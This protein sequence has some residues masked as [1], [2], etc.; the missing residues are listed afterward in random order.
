MRILWILLLFSISTTS[1]AQGEPPNPPS[2]GEVWK[3][4]GY[5]VGEKAG[6]EPS[7]SGSVLMPNILQLDGGGYRMYYNKSIPGQNQIKYAESTDGLNWTVKGVALQGSSNPQD[8]TYILGGPSVVKV[9][10]GYRM[11]YRCSPEQ[12]RGTAPKLHIRSAFSTDGINFKEE[13]IRIEIKSADPSSSL[14]LAGHGS[15]YRV[16]DGTFAAIFSANADARQ[17]SDLYSATSKDGLVWGNFKK[18]Y[19]G[20]HDPTVVIKDGKYYL[21]GMYLHFYHA[22]VISDDGVNWP[23]QMEKILLTDS[24]GVDLTEARVGVG[25][26]GAG[27][28]PDG[29]IRLYT[30]YG[31]PSSDIVVFEIED[32]AS[33]DLPPTVEVTSP[34]GGESFEPGDR[35]TVNWRSQDDRSVASHA[36]ELITDAGSSVTLATGITGSANSFEVTLPAGVTAEHARMRV[37]ATDSAG[38]TGSGVSG[39]FQIASKEPPDTLAPQ[40]RLLS[41]NGGERVR[42]GS[43]L[44]LQWQATDDRAVVSQD[45]F[46]STDG[47][48]SFPIRIASG[49]SGSENAFVFT[50]PKSI[51][52]S[53]RARVRVVV[54]DAAGN[55][56]Q[57]DSDGNFRIR[58]E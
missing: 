52:K 7:R 15:F 13:G 22:R 32:S 3:F 14:E 19:T 54:R 46:L 26:L 27:L 12:E 57:D 2:S 16:K 21:Y 25:D 23:A 42:I 55:S 48:A 4:K 31:N 44:T 24:T 50:L 41:P 36:I 38:K 34:V 17:P 47:G 30:N 11:Y 10:G 58:A 33:T 43:T 39:A 49:L 40:V 29:Q 5:C 6:N 18:L 53:K 37:T 51:S 1:Y 8:R 45:L 9:D 28:S 56:A 20:F 35:L